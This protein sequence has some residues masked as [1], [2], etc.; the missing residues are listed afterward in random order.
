MLRSRTV[1]AMSEDMD[2]GSREKSP[3]LEEWEAERGEIEL[4][5][6]ERETQFSQNVPA[7]E[8]PDP[9]A[10][11]PEKEGDCITLYKAE[12]AL[13]FDKLFQW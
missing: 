6:E 3:D 4:V 5:G 1:E 7:M 8:N 13:I 11:S 12:C 9:P 2:F 10:K